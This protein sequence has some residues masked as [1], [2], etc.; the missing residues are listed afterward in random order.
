M[1]TKLLSWQESLVL[2]A[3]LDRR[4]Q[5]YLPAQGQ[6]S[7]LT[8]SSLGGRGYYLRKSHITPTTTTNIGFCVNS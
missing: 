4:L 1:N 3:L 6:N 5:C 7:R 8:L 2:A